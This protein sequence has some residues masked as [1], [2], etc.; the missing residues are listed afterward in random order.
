[1]VNSGVRGTKD[2]NPRTEVDWYSTLIRVEYQ[3]SI[4]SCFKCLVPVNY[5]TGTPGDFVASGSSLVLPRAAADTRGQYS[6]PH[7][8]GASIVHYYAMQ[9]QQRGA[10]ERR[11]GGGTRERGKGRRKSLGL[12]VVRQYSRSS[13][14]TCRRA[15]WKEACYGGTDVTERSCAVA[16][17]KDINIKANPFTLYSGVWCGGL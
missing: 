13:G 8:T 16:R 3:L 12:L 2:R 11:R 7:Y 9:G 6:T 15:R 1:M 17:G 5:T 10:Q 4:L 14:D